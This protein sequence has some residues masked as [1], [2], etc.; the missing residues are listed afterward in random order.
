[1]RNAADRNV[2]TATR[3]GE[4]NDAGMFGDW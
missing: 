4:V 2:A 1:M 3:G